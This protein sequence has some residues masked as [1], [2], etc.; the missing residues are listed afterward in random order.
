MSPPCFLKVSFVAKSAHCGV[1]CGLRLIYQRLKYWARRV[2]H[3]PAH[4]H[5]RIAYLL[6][7]HMV[8]DAHL[9]GDLL[10]WLQAGTDFLVVAVYCLLPVPLP[11]WWFKCACVCVC[12][13]IYPDLFCRLLLSLCPHSTLS[14]FPFCFSLASRC[15]TQV[16]LARPSTTPTILSP[17]LS[18]SLLS[19]SL[20][21]PATFHCVPQ[22]WCDNSAGSDPLKWTSSP[23]LCS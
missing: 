3:R 23:V 11:A 7:L 14:F 8:V 10:P 18:F 16:A 20:S 13:S 4:S 1:S 17:V 21:P 9:A 12:V 15:L 6:T 22:I 2:I 5:M 19:L